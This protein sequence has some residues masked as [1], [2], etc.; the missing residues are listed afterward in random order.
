MAYAERLSW[1]VFPCSGKVPA[2]KGGRG[3][4]D[5]SSDPEIIARWW[6]DYPGANIGIATGKASG[7]TVLDLD[8]DEGEES[9]AALVHQHGAVP[10]TVEQLTG[11]GGR[12][13]LF[14]HIDGIGNR[15]AIRPGI[16][17]RGTGGYIVAAPSVH[18]N[19]Q[20]RYV[21]EVD[22]HP[23]DREIAEA[24][25]WLVT[26][27]RKPQVVQTHSGSDRPEWMQHSCG[28]IGEGARN[29]TLTRVVGHLLR[30]WVDAELAYRLIAA[31]NAQHCRPPLPEGELTRTFSSVLERELNRRGA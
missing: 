18:P 10:D 24:P 23:L 21:W 6:R 13:L 9:L 28:V 30:R 20:R 17:V 5:A 1:A 31:W 8:G 26:L 7:F 25:P 2:V 16:D 4:L 29:D 3:C 19:T 11:G 15:T 12:H 14:R 27:I 22:H